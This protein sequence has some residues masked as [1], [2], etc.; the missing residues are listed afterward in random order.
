MS[1]EILIATVVA[2]TLFANLGCAT[3]KYVQNQITPINN[4]IGE[5]ERHNRQEHSGHQRR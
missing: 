4:Q 1:K 3:K 2:T 5:S